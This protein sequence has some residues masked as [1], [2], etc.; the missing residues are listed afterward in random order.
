MIRDFAISA[1][2]ATGLSHTLRPYVNY[3]YIS[4]V[5][6]NDLPQFDTVDNVGDQ[7]LVTY[8]LDNFFTLRGQ[9]NDKKYD[10]NYGHIKLRQGYDFRS[11]ESD[12]PLTPLNMRLEYYPLN[13]L[14]FVYRTDV[15]M[16]G[17]GFVKHTVEG[18]YRNSRGDLFSVDYR[19]LKQGADVTQTNSI[20]TAASVGLYYNLRAGY[21]IERSIED[22]K[23]VQER[24]NLIYQ[25]SCWSVELA[26]NYIPGDQKITI[27]FRLANIGTPLGLDMP[28]L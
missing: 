5:D 19:Y 11:S 3:R 8:G 13:E 21:S 16:Y 12:T 4:D 20:K 9:H 27:M 2:S 1:G 28:G 10:R 24:F 18:D 17:D 6:Q 25:T 15:D 22:S 23:T 14:R 7:N 26:S